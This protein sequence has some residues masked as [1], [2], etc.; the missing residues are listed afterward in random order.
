MYGPTKFKEILQ[1]TDR[2][3][4]EK[5]IR[6]FTIDELWNVCVI[7]PKRVIINGIET[8]YDIFEVKIPYKTMVTQY[9]MPFE[10]L[11]DLQL[12]AQNKHYMNGVMKLA[13]DNSKIDLTIFD[14]V[15]ISTYDY[16]YEATRH[17][18][19]K[20]GTPAG[21][22]EVAGGISEGQDYEVNTKGINEHTITIT[23]IDTVKANVTKAKTWILDQTTEYIYEYVVVKDQQTVNDLE[24][25]L[26]PITEGS[27]DT[28]RKE[29]IKEKLEEKKWTKQQTIGQIIPSK[30]MA[31]WQND[32]GRYYEGADF[33][34]TSEGGKSVEYPRQSYADSDAPT[35]RVLANFL[36]NEA[37]TM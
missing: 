7:K 3:T 34:S 24:D 10:F 13:K 26:D 18:R 6:Y 5:A 37:R 8:R 25:Q 27:W 33:V 30:F 22:W 23:E 9:A 14:N 19:S 32:T 21:G 28:G 20:K 16:Q 36:T 35:D 12:T 2:S 31:L 15:E 17:T 29:T 4:K 11:F 1:T